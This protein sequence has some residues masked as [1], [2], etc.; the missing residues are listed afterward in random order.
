MAVLEPHRAEL[1]GV[2]VES[3]CNWYR[4]V[5]GLRENGYRVH[6]ATTAAIVRYA[7]RKH[8]RPSIESDPNAIKLGPNQL[9]YND[10]IGKHKNERTTTM[11]A[12]SLI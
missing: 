9:I 1:A 5:D 7:G 3:T 8:N 6:W 11:T 2:A 10:Q 12:T 4:P